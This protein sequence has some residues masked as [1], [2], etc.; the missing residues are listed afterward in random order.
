[1][2]FWVKCSCDCWQQQRKKNQLTFSIVKKT[3]RDSELQCSRNLSFYW[4]FQPPGTHWNPI[5]F[6]IFDI[7]KR[8]SIFLIFFFFASYLVSSS[9]FSVRFQRKANSRCINMQRDIYFLNFAQSTIFFFSCN[10]DRCKNKEN[11]NVRFFRKT[12][13]PEKKIIISVCCI[14]LWS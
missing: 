4:S 1:M 11:S 2:F 12:F 3:I 13:V 5:Y 14:D 9:S 7:I 10:F 8:S 6:I